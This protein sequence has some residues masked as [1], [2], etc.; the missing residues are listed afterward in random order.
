VD[1]VDGVDELVVTAID[2]LDEPASLIK[3]RD[4][5]HASERGSR[6]HDLPTSL[7]ASMIAEA[8]NTGPEPLICNDVPVLRRARL[9]WVNQ[10]FI[11]NETITEANACLVAEQTSGRGSRPNRWRKVGWVCCLRAM[12]EMR[13]LAEIRISKPKAGEL[14]LDYRAGMNGLRRRPRWVTPRHPLHDRYI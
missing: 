10:N 2:K 11:R 7:C 8:C 1:K 6:M 13:R 9:S 14:N 4:S 3:L 5:T 12:C